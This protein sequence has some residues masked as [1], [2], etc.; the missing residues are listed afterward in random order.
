MVDKSLRIRILEDVPGDIMLVDHELRRA[1][2]IVTIAVFISLVLFQSNACSWADDQRVTIKIGGTGGAMGAMTELAKVFH[3]K[4]PD[5][6]IIFVPNLGTSGGI[7]AVTAGAL[8]IGLAGKPL[9]PSE[10]ASGLKEVEYARSPF[11]FVT[12]HTGAGMNLTLEQ[13][14]RIYRGELKK[15]PDGTPIRLILRPEGDIDT[16]MLKGISPDLREAVGK[17]QSR[18]GMT[19]ALTDKDNAD[20]IEK[21]KGAFG[22]STLT[23][24]ISEKRALKPLPL[25]GVAPGVNTL[26]DGRYPYFRTFYMVTGPKSQSAAQSFIEFVKSQ[27]GRAILTKTGNSIPRVK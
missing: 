14:V 16:M 13:I 19:T 4:H 5:P 17:A 1:L 8:D 24:I 9:N 15:W 12:A 22:T 2:R 26:A 18:E 7:M 11:V 21:I 20:A 27:E 23:Q 10:L 6:D 25:N 3:K